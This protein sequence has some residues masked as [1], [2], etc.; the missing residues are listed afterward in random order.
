MIR[1]PLLALCS[2]SALAAADTKPALNSS[3]SAH[4]ELALTAYSV[5]DYATAAREFEAAYKSDPVPSLL[6]GW[7]QSERLGG[8]CDLAIPLYQKYLYAD[9]SPESIDAARTNIKQCQAV[10]PTAAPRPP[11]D[12]PPPEPPRRWYADPVADT[13]V[14]T[15]IAGVVVG[16][17]YVKKAGTTSDAAG[18]APSLSAFESDLQSATT[19][20][21][22]GYTALGVGIALAAVG[23]YLW[24]RHGHEQRA[25]IVATDGRSLVV[26]ARF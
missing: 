23:T 13:L 22:V 26:G 12:A 25:P 2:W 8:H 1:R 10:L 9:V 18:T 4:N 7:A 6:W 3:A 5:K 11:Q 16:I 20:R 14:V 21:R 15:G 19:D 24:V 17:L